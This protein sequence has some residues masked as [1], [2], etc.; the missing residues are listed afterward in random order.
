M[1]LFLEKGFPLHPFCLAHLFDKIQHLLRRILNNDFLAIVHNNS[2]FLQKYKIKI[3]PPNHLHKESLDRSAL[4]TGSA[5]GPCFSVGT[6]SENTGKMQ[7]V[8]PLQRDF[9]HLRVC[10]SLILFLV[11][12]YFFYFQTICIQP[13]GLCSKT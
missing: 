5:E 2:H 13:I 4:W 8:P 10:R 3:I 12:D 9:R 6:F 7:K 11:K 1:S